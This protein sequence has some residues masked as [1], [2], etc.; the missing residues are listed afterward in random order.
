[1]AKPVD[2]EALGSVLAEAQAKR[3]EVAGSRGEGKS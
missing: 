1:M 2:I 3:A